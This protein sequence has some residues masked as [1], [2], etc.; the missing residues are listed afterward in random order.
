MKPPLTLY[1]LWH[2]EFKD[3]E[4]YANAIFST[5]SRDVK[6][7]LT[8]G[9]GIPVY[10]RTGTEER[11]I[12]LPIEMDKSERTAVIA[13][14]DAKF[15]I[16]DEWTSYL[17]DIN[18]KISPPHI[19]YPVAVTGSAFNLESDIPEK[20]FIRLY[21]SEEPRKVEHLL[22]NLAQELCRLLYDRKR[23]ADS[24]SEL[25]PAPIKIFLSHAKAD[26]EELIKKLKAY[27]EEKLSADTFFDATD[28]AMGYKFPSEI[29]GNIKE[30]VL[31]VLHTDAYTTREWC[32]KEVIKAKRYS[33]PVV[34]INAFKKGEKRSFPYMANVPNIKWDIES[35]E[36]KD[37][38]FDKLFSQ[39]LTESLRFRFHRENIKYLLSIFEVEFEDRNILAYPPEL[40]T[41][42]RI[43]SLDK[44]LMVYPDPPLG[45][46]ESGLL[47]EFEPDVRFI[48]PTTLP[49]LE[50]DNQKFLSDTRV[51]VSI[52]E[53]PDSFKYGFKLVHFQDALVEC[54]RYLLMCGASVAYGGNIRY[55]KDLN[56]ATLLFDLLIL[57]SVQDETNNP[58]PG[59]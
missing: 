51:G 30:S 53:C 13:L 55:D 34:V 16:D 15:V 41:F 45:D 38:I 24:G 49:L 3:G 12:P 1:V 42:L 8:R 58:G 20:N 27:I 10:F 47:N 23:L 54:A 56:F 26:G 28:I 44:K 22:I 2:Q 19:L 31:L 48:T 37:I 52:S 50:S 9:I 59:R 32:R 17:N 40:F 43:K 35:D 36:S 57:I 21:E 4:K 25:S 14:I 11:N 39:V 6:E 18:D 46:A 33:S 29:D 7:P 5:F